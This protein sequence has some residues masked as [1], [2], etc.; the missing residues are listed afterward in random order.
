VGSPERLLIFSFRGRLFSDGKTIF[1]WR[2]TLASPLKKEKNMYRVT[3]LYGHPQDPA[4]FER[5]YRQTHLPLA[6]RIREIKGLTIGKLEAV[7]PGQRAEYYRVASLYFESREAYQGWRASPAGQAMR[8]D[9]NNFATGG[10]TVVADEEEV[11]VPVSLT[12]A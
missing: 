7:V 4:E 8:A 11:L 3:V 10:V 9:L 6:A 1:A 2:W 12:S 5:Y